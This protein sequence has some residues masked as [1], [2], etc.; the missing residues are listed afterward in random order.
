VHVSQLPL[1]FGLLVTIGGGSVANEDGV[2]VDVELTNCAIPNLAA[3][4]RRVS[5]IISMTRGIDTP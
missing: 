5:R 3:I 4:K 1:N 2:I